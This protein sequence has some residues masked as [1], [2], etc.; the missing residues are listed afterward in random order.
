MSGQRFS[1]TMDEDKDFNG[2]G[3]YGNSVM[4][5]PTKEE[6]PQMTW[7]DPA[8]ADRFEAY[9]QNDKYLSK[10]RGQWADRLG[11]IAP[12]EHHFDLHIA[13]DFYYD[14]KSGRKIQFLVD[15]L[16]ISNLFN[17]EWGLYY[18]ADYNVSPLSVTDLTADASGNMTPT[19]KYREDKLYLDE[20]YSRWRCQIGLR[21]TF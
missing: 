16:N 2:D 8:D 9:I 5:I 6:L 19:Y 1:Y 3:Q 18:A 21:L 20:F 14:R 4:Y 13:Q 10:H 15:F 12:F 11:G 7:A 17:R